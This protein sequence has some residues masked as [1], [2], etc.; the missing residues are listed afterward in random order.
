MCDNLRNNLKALY[1]SKD[2]TVFIF[3][4]KDYLFIAIK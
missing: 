4:F 3:K 2:F 1:S